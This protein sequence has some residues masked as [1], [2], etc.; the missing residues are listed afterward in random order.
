MKLFA[1]FLAA[2][3]TVLA[4]AQPGTG[5]P[6]VPPSAVTQASPTP[7]AQSQAAP[8][9]ITAYTLSPE[10]YRK[11][12]NRARIGFATRIV[13]FFYGLAILWFILR[14]KLAVRFRDWAEKTSRLRVVQAFVSVSYTHL[15]LPTKRIV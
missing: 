15:T 5:R 8:A 14:S 3:F 10:Q 4:I 11:A 7:S 9:R 2:F 6:Q 13:A 12:R 1:L